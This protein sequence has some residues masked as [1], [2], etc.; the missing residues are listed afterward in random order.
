MGELLEKQIRQ[1]LRDLIYLQVLD[2]EHIGQL[3]QGLDDLFSFIG[4][5]S[6]KTIHHFL[7]NGGRGM[8]S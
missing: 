5:E 6:L 2:I 8:F 7:L 4:W 1:G 3:C